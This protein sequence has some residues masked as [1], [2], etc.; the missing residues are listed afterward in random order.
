MYSAV[1]I[2]D[3]LVQLKQHHLKSLPTKKWIRFSRLK[4]NAQSETFLNRYVRAQNR[5]E[6]KQASHLQSSNIKLIEKAPYGAVHLR[7]NVWN[8]NDNENCR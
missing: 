4:F 6:K 7:H 2:S 8:A 3:V 1:R 5:V